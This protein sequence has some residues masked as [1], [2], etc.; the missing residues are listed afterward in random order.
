MDAKLKQEMQAQA[1]R[2]AQT[3]QDMQD[4]LTWKHGQGITWS[5]IY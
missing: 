4:Y 2:N 5:Q 3:Q 1:K